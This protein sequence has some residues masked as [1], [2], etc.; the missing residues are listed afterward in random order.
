[1]LKRLCLYGL[2]LLFLAMNKI[3]VK[4]PT[5]QRPELFLSTLK[6][7][8]EFAA[9]NSRIIYL[10]SYD[11]DDLTMTKAVLDEALNLPAN[12]VLRAGL[13]KSK[14]EAC[15]RDI[16]DIPATM[17]DI[18][19]LISD[20]MHVQKIGWDDIIRKDFDKFYPENSDGCLWYHDGSKQKVISTLS[21]MGREYYERFMYLYHPSYKSFF[22]DN[23]YTDVAKSLGKLP[24]ID[25]AIIKHEHPQWGG[26]VEHDAL[27]E[28]NNGPWDE[29]GK[30]Y[31]QR[32]TLKFPL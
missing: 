28:R 5:R 18:I 29:D 24:F 31:R 13:S 1:M 27:Y 3:L 14:I 8:V 11:S 22:C 20:D 26:G 4:Y 25:H 17:Y 12:I 2:C 32:Q 7:Y 19:L 6:K 23:E 21:C 30:N 10:I 9:D 16:E 15:N